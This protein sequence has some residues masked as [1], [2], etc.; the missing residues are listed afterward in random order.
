MLLTLSVSLP[1]LLPISL[2]YLQSGELSII[3]SL[4]VLPQRTWAESWIVWYYSVSSTSSLLYWR[5]VADA[6]IPLADRVE[7]LGMTLV[8][9]LPM[10]DHVAAVCKAAFYHFR[11]LRHSRPAIA[12]KMLK[13]LSH[14]Q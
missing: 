10:D 7:I 13:R 12:D 8:S 6:V 11:A 2:A 9:R 4:L 5:H 14:A 1:Y 3:A